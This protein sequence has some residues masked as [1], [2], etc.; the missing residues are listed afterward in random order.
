MLRTFPTVWLIV[1]MWA[2]ATAFF[3][4][5]LD[6]RKLA[7]LVILLSLL[8]FATLVHTRERAPAT[9]PA[10]LVDFSSHVAAPN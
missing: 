2:T 5:K 3:L 9:G 8:L 10:L 4:S 7:V 1:V 6:K